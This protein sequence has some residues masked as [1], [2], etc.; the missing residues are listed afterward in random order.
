MVMSITILLVKLLCKNL[1]LQKIIDLFSGNIFL[2]IVI[3]IQISHILL[4][5]SKLSKN[6][7]TLFHTM[8]LFSM[9]YVACVIRIFVRHLKERMWM[10]IRRD[11]YPKVQ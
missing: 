9:S 5:R 6:Y 11:D 10:N 1:Y 3:V 8:L 2:V 7:Y 4:V